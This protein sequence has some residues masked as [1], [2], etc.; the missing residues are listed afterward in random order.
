M[1]RGVRWRGGALD[2]CMISL[3]GTVETAV[4]RY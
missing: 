1:V 2:N 3:D 4:C